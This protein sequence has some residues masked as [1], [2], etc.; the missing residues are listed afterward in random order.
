M[1]YLS[2]EDKFASFSEIQS[3]TLEFYFFPIIKSEGKTTE[4]LT[5]ARLIIKKEI[6]LIFWP[7]K[8]NDGFNEICFSYFESFD[9]WIA[10]DVMLSFNS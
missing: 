6:C 10:R 5:K 7:S 9:F 8:M 3:S 4:T 2:L 1:L